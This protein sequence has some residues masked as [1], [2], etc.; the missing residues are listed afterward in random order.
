MAIYCSLEI[1][2]PPTIRIDVKG[3]LEIRVYSIN[4]SRIQMAGTPDVRQ[5]IIGDGAARD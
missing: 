3:R 5:K 2:A 1:V 4:G